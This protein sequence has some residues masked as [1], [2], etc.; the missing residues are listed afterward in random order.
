MNIVRTFLELD[1]LYESDDYT[2][3]Q[4]LI[5][6]LRALNRYYNFGRFSNDQLYRM[7]RKAEI[8]E[9]E[10]EAYRELRKERAIRDSYEYCE[11]CNTRLNPLGQ[12]PICDLGDRLD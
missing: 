6:S 3:R 9:S 10:K 12:C 1:K 2:Y 11:N 4:E 7:L 5:S 8:E